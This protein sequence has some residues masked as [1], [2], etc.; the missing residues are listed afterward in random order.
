MKSNAFPEVESLRSEVRQLRE[1]V[2][3]LE[4]RLEEY[5]SEESDAEAENP[6]GIW[7]YCWV[8]SGWDLAQDGF[9]SFHKNLSDWSL[10]RH[11]RR[12]QQLAQQQE[13][14]ELHLT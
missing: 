3:E 7:P 10:K 9:H 5:E 8:V 4:G 14:G 13:F 2:A 1:A 11:N 12:V 6:W